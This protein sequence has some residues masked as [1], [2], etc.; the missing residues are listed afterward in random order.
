MESKQWTPW[1][2][3]YDP[4]M[5]NGATVTEDEHH[6]L[7]ETADCGERC[8][9]CSLCCE[10]YRDVIT[11]DYEGVE[12]FAPNLKLGRGGL[13]KLETGVWYRPVMCGAQCPGYGQCCPPFELRQQPETVTDARHVL[14]ERTDSRRWEMEAALQILAHAG[15]PEAVEILHTYL[16]QAHTRLACFAELALE[17]GE[18]FANTPGTPAEAQMMMKHEV[19]RAWEDRLYEAMAKVQDELEPELERRRYEYEIAKHL[20]DAAQDEASHYEWDIQASVLH[21]IMIIAKADLS[22]QRQE[23]AICE[24]M[25]DAIEAD[26]ALAENGIQPTDGPDE[27]D[28]AETLGANTDIPF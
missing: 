13:I 21:D 5:G 16:P 25:V 19:L 20:R 27:P 11:A 23:I 7:I 8:P 26:L 28:S 4:R 18:F 15:T 10:G 9:G 22:E 14:L 12:E 1:T 6:R 2:P 3:P 24:A 17:E